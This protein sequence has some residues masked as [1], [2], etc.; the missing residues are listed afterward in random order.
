MKRKK[1]YHFLLLELLIAMTLF[2]TC[3]LPLTS[4][5]MKTLR[6]QI[7]TYQRL[8]LQ[9][10]SEET[11]AIVLSKLYRQEISWE[12]LKERS[13]VLAA[14]Q[15]PLPLKGIGQRKVERTVYVETACQKEGQH[16]TQHRLLNIDIVFRTLKDRHFF[17]FKNKRKETQTVRYRIHIRQQDVKNQEPSAI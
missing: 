11:L 17:I 14:E 12:K 2:T 4:I 7:Q 13:V 10:I 3:I 1:T 8:Q 16:S 15:I 5:P 6:E 9:R